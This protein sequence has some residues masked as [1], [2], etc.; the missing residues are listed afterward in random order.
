M[1]VATTPWRRSSA[2]ERLLARSDAAALDALALLVH[3]LPVEGDVLLDG[4]DDG[5][6]CLRHGLDSVASDITRW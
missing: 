6:V 2:F 1:R 5:S 4:A 3:A